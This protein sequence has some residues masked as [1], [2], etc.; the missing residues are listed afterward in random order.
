M[1]GSI[2]VVLLATTLHSAADEHANINTRGGEAKK[3]KED[4]L[5]CDREHICPLAVE[6]RDGSRCEHR[7]PRPLVLGQRLG[8]RTKFPTVN[9]RPL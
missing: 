5:L 4:T 1:S 9:Q 7:E 2:P 8:E 3:E 6:L